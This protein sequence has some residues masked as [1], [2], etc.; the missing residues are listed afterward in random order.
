VYPD[1]R[2]ALLEDELIEVQLLPVGDVQQ[3]AGIAYRLLLRV[4]CI[5]TWD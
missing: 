2:S 3:D 4:T 1:G 5:T